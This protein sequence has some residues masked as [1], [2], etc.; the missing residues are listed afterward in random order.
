M[1]NKMIKPPWQF[2]TKL[3]V[4]LSYC[5]ASMYPGIYTREL[6]TCPACRC[7]Q[8]HNGP[9]LEAAKL[10]FNSRIDKYTVA[11]SDNRILFR[12]EKK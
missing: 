5:P 11:Y 7:L 9:N 3:K 6:K 4:I 10:S 2:L 8:Q 1:E 12:A